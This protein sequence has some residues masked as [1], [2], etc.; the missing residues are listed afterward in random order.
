MN[1]KTKDGAR[2]KGKP[3]FLRVPW[4]KGDLVNTGPAWLLVVSTTPSQDVEEDSDPGDDAIIPTTK[5]LKTFKHIQHDVDLR[6]QELA[7][8]NGQGKFKM[9]KGGNDQVTVKQQIPWSQIY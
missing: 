5:F 8:I 9:K 4:N 3:Y 6:L 2:N 1:T 7:K